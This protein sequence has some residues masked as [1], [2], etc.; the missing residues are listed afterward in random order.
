MKYLYLTGKKFGKL[1]V[2]KML[3]YKNNR[4]LWECKCDCGKKIITQG[5]S[6]TTGNTK[7]CGCVR[8]EKIAKSLTTHNKR[9][10]P[11]YA[12][13]AS[14]KYRCLNKNNKSY[15]YYG[16]RGI[17]VCKRWLKFENFYNDMS[18]GYKNGFTLD[19]I[20]NNGNYYKENC[21]WVSFFTQARNRRSSKIY[22]YKNENKTLAEFAEK[23]GFKTMQLIHRLRRGWS[24]QKSLET[25]IKIT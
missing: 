21:R 11:L 5:T 15:S 3:G 22:N 19:R 25:P 1:L 8:K 2:I 10:H 9:H 12:I 20:N 13:W 16:G 24:L 23:Y 7:S 4:S 14:M 6:L 17:K 18:I